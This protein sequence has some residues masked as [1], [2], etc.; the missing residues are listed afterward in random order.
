MAQSGVR[1][2]HD[3]L[4]AVLKYHIVNG[5]ITTDRLAEMKKIRSLLGKQLTIYKK[6][7]VLMVDD[8][9]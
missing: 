3:E 5:K 6:N 7:N 9:G 4:K 2:H 1:E 8:A